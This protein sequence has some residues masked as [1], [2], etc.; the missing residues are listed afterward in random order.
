MINSPPFRGPNSL[1]LVIS[2][3]PEHFR[4]FDGVNI[5][6]WCS[7]K[8]VKEQLERHKMGLCF[9]QLDWLCGSGVHG[10]HSPPS[11]GPN[12]LFLV[13]SKFPEHFR[14]VDDVP[15]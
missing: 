14:S 12:S 2:K 10:I 3:F 5:L 8:K 15:I 4:S 1:F 7:W 6:F 9:V 13:V 11:R